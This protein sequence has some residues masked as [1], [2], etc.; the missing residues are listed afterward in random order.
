LAIAGHRESRRDARIL[1]QNLVSL[2]L[3]G[4]HARICLGDDPSRPIITP[5]TKLLSPM[6]KKALGTTM[7]SQIVPP[8]QIN[9]ISADIQRKRRNHQSDLP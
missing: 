4:A 3:E 8:K 1:P 9:Q 6:G 7:K 5:Q 2:V